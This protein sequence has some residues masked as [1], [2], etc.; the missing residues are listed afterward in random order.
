MHRK[1]LLSSGDVH[2]CV[3]EAQRELCLQMDKANAADVGPSLHMSTLD[4]FSP[5]SKALH[6]GS[7]SDVPSLDQALC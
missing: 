5:E 2:L 7:V 3:G 4:V 1:A 6:L